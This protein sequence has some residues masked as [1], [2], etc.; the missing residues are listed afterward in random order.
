ML[1]ITAQN[2]SNSNPDPSFYLGSKCVTLV[3]VR[4]RNYRYLFNAWKKASIFNDQEKKTIIFDSLVSR[5]LSVD[6]V[7]TGTI[8]RY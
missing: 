2:G 5:M 6:C 1:S 7:A 8:T 4:Y 3:P